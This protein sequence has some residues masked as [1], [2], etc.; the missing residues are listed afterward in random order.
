[1]FH[2]VHAV[3]AGPQFVEIDYVADHRFLPAPVSARFLCVARII[4]LNRLFRRAPASPRLQPL[5]RRCGRCSLQPVGL[6][7]LYDLLRRKGFPRQIGRDNHPGI[8]RS[9][10][11]RRNRISASR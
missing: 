7:I 6:Q 3:R 5:L 11:R 4:R 8:A 1:M 9:A 2:A 10:C